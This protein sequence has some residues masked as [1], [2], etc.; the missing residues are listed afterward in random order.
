MLDIMY[1]LPDQQAGLEYVVTRDV[2][3]GRE[4]LFPVPEAKH[5]SA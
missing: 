4:P 1:E 2:V 3:L 5:K